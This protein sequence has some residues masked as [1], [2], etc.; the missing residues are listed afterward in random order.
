M[1][2][3]FFRPAHRDAAEPAIVAALRAVGASVWSVSG[4]DIPDLLVGYKGRTYLLEVKTPGRAYTDK[5]NGRTYTRDG[6]LS[7]GQKAFFESWRGGPAKEVFTPEEALYAI[8]APVESV[9]P[10][11]PKTGAVPKSGQ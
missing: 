1:K 5:R 4:K 6:T 11:L 3:A 2:R 8:G 10:P 9:L 7:A